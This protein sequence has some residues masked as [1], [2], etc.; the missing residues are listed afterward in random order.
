M[1]NT[2][3]KEVFVMRRK[4]TLCVVFLLL[5][6]LLCTGSLLAQAKVTLVVSIRG[7]DNP[8]HANYAVG[9]KALGEILKLPVDVLSTEANSQKGI[10][11]VKAEVAK[12]G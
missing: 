2:K 5:A 8:Y 3:F 11:D 4:L 10:S 12:T 6:G 9:A 1:L 7:L